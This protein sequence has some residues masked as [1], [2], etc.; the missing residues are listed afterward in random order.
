M[1]ITWTRNRMSKVKSPQCSI[2]AIMKTAAKNLL[3]GGIQAK[4]N[5]YDV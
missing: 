1:K 4:E 5:C 3:A 2:K